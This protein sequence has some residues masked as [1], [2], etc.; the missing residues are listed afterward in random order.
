MERTVT[1]LWN[2]NTA[3]IAEII[4]V[5]NGYTDAVGGGGSADATI[6]S[7]DTFFGARLRSLCLFWT[8]TVMEGLEKL[9]RYKMVKLYSYSTFSQQRG[10]LGTPIRT[11][12]TGDG[13]PN[14]NYALFKALRVTVRTIDIILVQMIQVFME[15]R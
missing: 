4:R 7:I 3:L 11:E 14:A 1:V 2:T 15:S 9:F 5:T 6:C 12:D 13:N 10:F 8:V